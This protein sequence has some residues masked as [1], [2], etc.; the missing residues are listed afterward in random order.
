[1]LSQGSTVATPSARPASTT[2]ARPARRRGLTVSHW[3]LRPEQAVGLARA[4]PE[5][6]GAG[7]SRVP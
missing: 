7:V 5:L 2:L 6:T 3:Q 4:E 1:M